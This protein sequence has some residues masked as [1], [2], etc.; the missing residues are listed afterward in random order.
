[1]SAGL[2]GRG[3]P[4]GYPYRPEYEITPRELRDL[5]GSG[6][7]VVLVDC[8]REDEHRVARI[9]GSVLIPLPEIDR[10][11]EEIK[12]LAAEAGSRSGSAALVAVHCH[13]GVRSLRAALTLRGHGIEAVSVAG[14]IELWSIDIDPAVPRY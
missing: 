9:E 1:M 14:G 6:A 10:R 7:A 2:D 3:L 8:R 4:L 5:M 13:H 11:A 12:E